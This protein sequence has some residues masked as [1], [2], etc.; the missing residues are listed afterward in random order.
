MNGSREVLSTKTANVSL[1]PDGVVEVRISI[2]AKQALADA[3]ENLTAAIRVG[4]GARRGFLVD[5]RLS[6]MLEPDA[7]HYYATQPLDN[8]FT[9]LAL[10]LEANPLGVMMGNVYMKM[11]RHSVP[12]KLFTDE[13]EALKW[14][15]TSS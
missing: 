9:K 10:L 7:R 14:L 4:T 15:K 1:R 11:A 6:E 2:G 12:I 13:A 3:Q 5:I 8:H